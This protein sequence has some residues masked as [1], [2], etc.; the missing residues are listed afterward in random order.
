MV[1]VTSE[2]RVLSSSRGFGTDTY[3]PFQLKIVVDGT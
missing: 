3:V 2:G 1:V